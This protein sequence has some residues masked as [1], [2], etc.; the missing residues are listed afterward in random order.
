MHVYRSCGTS[1]YDHHYFCDIQQVEFKPNECLVYIEVKGNGSKGPLQAPHVSKLYVGT[2]NTPVPIKNYVSSI[3][4][5]N[6]KRGYYVYD[7]FHF[8]QGRAV[9]FQYGASGYSKQKIVDSIP[10]FMNG[11]NG[12]GLGFS[13]NM[14]PLSFSMGTSGVNVSS[15]NYPN[16]YPGTITTPTYIPPPMTSSYSPTMNPTPTYSPTM[17]PTP[18]YSPTMNPTPTYDM[19]MSMSS[20]GMG[21]NTG[22]STSG[23]GMNTSMTS[24]GMGM[25]TSMNY[26]YTS[27]NINRGEN[28]GN[29]HGDTRSFD[30]FSFITGKTYAPIRQLNLYASTTNVNGI[31][32]LYD[33]NLM[34]NLEMG[35]HGNPTLQT[36]Y[37]QP[38]EFIS[39]VSGSYS[40]VLVSLE[41]RTSLGRSMRVGGNGGTPF[42]FANP[43]GSQIVGFYGG[44]G[45]HMHNIGYYYM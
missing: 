17:N 30:H 28:F 25:N 39:D 23:M 1:R 6:H 41:I 16:N 42:R 40:N 36:L 18:I 11:G 9:Y 4:H 44:C 27:G 19:G 32:V 29:R 21:M 14:G 15:S 34:T 13:I 7:A 45:G 10:N 22:M 26:G 33:G 12:S 31:Q 5:P 43:Y 20:S 2:S 3:D 37:L 38:G 8:V 35:N 24:S